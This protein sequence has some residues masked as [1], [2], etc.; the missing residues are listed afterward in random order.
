MEYVDGATINRILAR[1]RLSLSE[2]LDYAI[3]IAGTAET[4][5]GEWIAATD[6]KSADVSSATG[7]VGASI[8]AD[9]LVFAQGEAVGNI[10]MMNLPARRS[11]AGSSPPA[12]GESLCNESG[13]FLTIS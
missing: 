6:G 2:V 12:C 5:A 4:R 7:P 13:P 9:K 10:R 1:R 11:P 8:A 3:Q